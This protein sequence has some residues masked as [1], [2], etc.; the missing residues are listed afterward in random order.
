MS[1]G[2]IISVYKHWHLL[3][4]AIDSVLAQTFQDW[5]LYVI[6]DEDHFPEKVHRDHRITYNF[7]QQHLGLAKRINQGLE[8]CKE[9]YVLILGADDTISPHYLDHVAKYLEKHQSLIWLYGDCLVQH[10]GGIERYQ[11]GIFSRKKLQKINYIPCCSVV[12]DAMLA[13][14]F[15]YN[16]KLK[17]AEDWEMWLLLSRFYKPHY[18]PEVAY[19]RSDNTS[20]M[21]NDITNKNKFMALKRRIKRKLIKRKFRRV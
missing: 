10:Q 16:E 14:Q 2:I 21:R 6:G 17:W 18:L 12:C 11:P 5:R 7:D 4:K 13:R 3:G 15:R 8:M 9:D 1:I 19:T 20:I